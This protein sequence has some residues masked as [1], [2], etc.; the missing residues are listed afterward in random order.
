MK[1]FILVLF[2]VC[3]FLQACTVFIGEP[4]NPCEYSK[5]NDSLSINACSKHY[6]KGYHTLN[7]EFYSKYRGYIDT[8]RLFCR[9]EDYANSCGSYI[10]IKFRGQFSP[11]DDIGIEEMFYTDNEN[12]YRYHCFDIESHYLVLNRGGNR[13]IKF[14]SGYK[15]ILE[16]AFTKKE[17]V[18]VKDEEG[19]QKLIRKTF[20]DKY[21]SGQIEDID[22]IKGSVEV[23]WIG[24]NKD[25]VIKVFLKPNF[26]IKGLGS[27]WEHR[28]KVALRL[29]GLEL[30]SKYFIVQPV[31]VEYYLDSYVLSF[32]NA[33]GQVV[34]SKI[35]EGR[36][37]TK[38]INEEFE[39]L[40][41]N[42]GFTISEVHVT[43]KFKGREYKLFYPE[44]YYYKYSY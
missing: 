8:G 37:F 40:K 24:I 13:R 34:S 16:K 43:A 6:S 39:N 35:L 22:K 29:L 4:E 11:N 44:A 42:E 12:G 20:A 23:V 19:K 31:E 41:K 32:F 36:R 30:K 17:R 5:L 3:L 2:I 26:S 15:S 7:I 33:Q 1:P 27:G 21:K 38:G 28:P 14:W 10:K 9:F 18:I 25:S